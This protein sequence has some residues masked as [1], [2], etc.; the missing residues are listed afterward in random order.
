MSTLP[1]SWITAGSRGLWQIK[2]WTTYSSIPYDVLPPVNAEDDF[3]FLRTLRPEQPAPSAN[4]TNGHAAHTNGET[5]GE[6]N[7][8]TNGETNGESNACSHGHHHTE[9]DSC[10]SDE[11]SEFEDVEDMHFEDEKN[12][13]AEL[14]KRIAEAAALG[15]EIP[16]TFIDFFT[17]FRKLGKQIPTPTACFFSLGTSLIKVK[18]APDNVR[19]LRFLNDQQSCVFWLLVLEPGKPTAVISGYPLWDDEEDDEDEDDEADGAEAKED[20]AEPATGDK[21][22]EEDK[23]EVDKD[24]WDAQ[25]QLAEPSICAPSFPEFMKRLFLENTL[26]F[27]LGGWNDENAPPAALK[28]ELEAYRDAAAKAVEEGE[29][30]AALGE[31]RF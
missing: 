13:D 5:N 9:L 29:V 3:A 4:G 21:K 18:G 16:A 24:D 23:V 2:G 26:W 11:E 20:A 28:A 15:L 8:E 12:I 27:S 19:A 31:D 6:T 25:Y 22:D 14:Q 1:K 7:S 10:S 30:P 17:N